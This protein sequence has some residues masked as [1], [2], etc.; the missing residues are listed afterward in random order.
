MP[1]TVEVINFSFGK[2]I[3]AELN[4]QII[5]NHS[6]KIINVGPGKL[7]RANFVHGGSVACPP[8]VRK[9]APVDLQ[10]FLLCEQSALSDNGRAPVNNGTEDVKKQRPDAS[11]LSRRAVRLR[12]QQRKRGHE[13][14][15]PHQLHRFS[16]LVKPAS[17]LSVDSRNL[18]F[19]IEMT[20]N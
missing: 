5:Q 12:S 13:G 16:P 3:E 14:R 11:A 20:H 4:D 15:E 10:V 17:C 18:I 9:C 19:G 7:S 1:G 6:V 8:A 2:A